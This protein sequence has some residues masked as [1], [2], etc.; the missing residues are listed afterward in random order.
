VE[1]RAVG[2]DTGEGRVR[3]AIIAGERSTS[4]SGLRGR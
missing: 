3:V 4:R 1:D 2:Q